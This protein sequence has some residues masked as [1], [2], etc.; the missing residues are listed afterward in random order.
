[1]TDL[2]DEVAVV[3]SCVRPWVIGSR[4]RIELS[5]CN[6][7]EGSDLTVIHLAIA[8]EDGARRPEMWLSGAR[9]TTLFAISGTKSCSI[10]HLYCRLMSVVCCGQI[11]SVARTRDHPTALS[12]GL[13]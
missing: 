3:R 8:R 1:M 6:G 5:R 12:F 7:K 9:F 2:T 11:D 10:V 13:R 4:P